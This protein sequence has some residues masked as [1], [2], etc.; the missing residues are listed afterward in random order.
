MQRI[1]ITGFTLMELL[2]T[3]SIVAIL[4]TIAI[5]SFQSMITRMRMDS[6]INSLITDLNF[7]R[8]E[9]IK[10][11]LPINVCPYTGNICNTGVPLNWSTGWM[12]LNAATAQPLRLTAAL[13]HGDTMTSNLASGISPIFSPVGYPQFSG[14]ITLHDSNDDQ[15]LRRCIQFNAGSWQLLTGASCP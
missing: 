10:Q 15:N 2:I 12:V 4:A 14:F 8:S 7:G 5:P 13:T 1:K 3:M 9:A 11:G 6:E